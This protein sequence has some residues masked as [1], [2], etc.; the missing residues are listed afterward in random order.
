MT[1]MK[2]TCLMAG[3]LI[4]GCLSTVH[5]AF[6]VGDRGA[7]VTEIQKQLSRSGIRVEADGYY[8]RQTQQAIKTFQ[9][10]HR[11]AADGVVGPATYKALTGKDMPRSAA[12]PAGGAS[13]SRAYGGVIS[14][15]AEKIMTEARK[16]LG[17]PYRFG[18]VAPDGFDCSGFIRFVYARG[19]IALPRS[20]DE[21]YNVGKNVSMDSLKP[22][23]LVFF[24]TYEKGVSH[25]GIYVGNGSF[26]SA[27]TSRGVAVADLMHGYWREHYVGAKRIL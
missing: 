11:L 17:T 15:D 26:I 3:F 16:Y 7:S 25:S 21:Q 4:V 8:G 9:K 22:G 27:T 13:G 6:S 19:G 20:A 18:G 5:A 2:V 1:R 24:S 23:D 10:R 12:Y 14:P